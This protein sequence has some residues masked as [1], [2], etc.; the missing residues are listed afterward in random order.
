VEAVATLA[1]EV[2][3]AV[4]NIDFNPCNLWLKM[5]AYG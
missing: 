4:G 2:R 3:A 1:A 5:V